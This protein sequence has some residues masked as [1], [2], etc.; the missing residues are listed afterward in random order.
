MYLTSSDTQCTVHVDMNF[1]QPMDGLITKH[2][3]G[4]ALHA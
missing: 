4:H 3:T 1:R 2:R